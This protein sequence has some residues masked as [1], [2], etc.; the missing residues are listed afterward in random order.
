VLGFDEI[1]GDLGC[2]GSL[3]ERA[4]RLSPVYWLPFE[5]PTDS[6]SRESDPGGVDGIVQLRYLLSS[7]RARILH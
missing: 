6:V 4:T 5:E 2:V 7:C 3:S 1:E